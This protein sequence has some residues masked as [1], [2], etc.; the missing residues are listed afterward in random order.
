MS[1][2]EFCGNAVRAFGLLLA[3]ANDLPDGSIPV[4]ISG[5]TG[6]IP[7]TVDR[8]TGF[9]TADIPLPET[10]SMVSLP[11]PF[12]VCPLIRFSGIW[13][14]IAEGV[15]ATEQNFVL[16][17]DAVYTR[18]QPEAFGVMFLSPDMLSMTPYV[19]VN[20][21]GTLFRENS[22]GS[23]TAAVAAWFAANG[24]TGSFSLQQPGGRLQIRIDAPNGILRRLSLGGEVLLEEPSVITLS[25]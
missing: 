7:V 1:G 2:G 11:A 20:G 12:G 9:V 6:P 8:S 21:S 22:C 23:G 25:I 4:E 24:K 3:L 18:W 14:A 19:Y 10:I 16:A 5:C 15:P 17:R 13:H